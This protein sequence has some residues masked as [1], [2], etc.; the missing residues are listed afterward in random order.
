M[1]LKINNKIYN[2]FWVDFN[3]II[4]YLRR[5]DEVWVRLIR[6]GNLLDFSRG[7]VVLYAGGR[8]TPCLPSGIK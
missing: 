2:K 3:S 6:L 1:E 5:H 7:E 4:I 8:N